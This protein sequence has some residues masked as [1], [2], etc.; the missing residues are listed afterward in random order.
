MN[1]NHGFALIGLLFAFVILA[2]SIYVVTNR[3]SE[4]PALDLLSPP[5]TSS[6]DSSSAQIQNVNVLNSDTYTIENISP[7]DYDPRVHTL[8]DDPSQL[9]P[10]TLKALCRRETDITAEAANLKDIGG[11][12]ARAG[13]N[14]AYNI[15]LSK[16]GLVE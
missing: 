5:E 3:L 16:F 7:Q 13:I 11:P 8:E 1:K 12:A 9:N 4:G 2:V 10:E 14:T 15:C 6:E